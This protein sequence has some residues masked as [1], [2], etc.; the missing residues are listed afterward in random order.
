MILRP[1][2]V[3]LAL[4]LAAAVAL[5]AERGVVKTTVAGKA[6]S[7]E[8]G[9]PTLQ[10]RDMLSRAEI[11]TP[12]RMGADAPTRLK[13]AATL[14]FGS[15][16]VVAPGDYVLTATKT[17][18]DAWQIDFKTSDAADGPAVVA[19]PLVSKTL[20]D[21]VET[22]TIDLTGGKDSGQLALKWGTKSLTTSFTAR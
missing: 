1:A 15:G 5:P 22:F 20:P 13:T 17:A 2:A 14:T 18:E 8:Y 21:S 16:I 6:I 7:I 12:W 10:G 19:V 11:G 3:T 4:A 9:R